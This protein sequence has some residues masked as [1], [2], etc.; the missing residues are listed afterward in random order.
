GCKQNNV[1]VVY[2][3]WSN[4]KKTPGMEVGQVSFHDDKG[5][6]KVRVE[7]KENSITNRLMKT[8]SESHPNLREQREERDRLERMAQRKEESLQREREK[9]EAKKREEMKKLRSYDSLMKPEKMTTNADASGYDS[10][11][12]M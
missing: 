3:I 4:L 10:D 6:R 11:D 8:K 7:R 2:T 1:D 5:V 9:E 12:F